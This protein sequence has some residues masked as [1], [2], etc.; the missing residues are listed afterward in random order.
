MTMQTDVQS[1]HLNVSGFAVLGRT[2]LRGIIVVGSATAGTV[3]IWDSV[4]APTAAATGYTRA[5]T[6]I[7]TVTSASHGLQ[8]GGR[9]GL[10]FAVQGS[11]GGTN[12]NY[13]ILTADANTFTVQDINLAAIAS[14]TACS[15]LGAST[16]QTQWMMSFD[17]AAVTSGSQIVPLTLPGEG[18]L[19]EVGI[20]I[21]MSNQTGA[22]IFYG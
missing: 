16:N 9:V 6:G 10:T 4:T 13:T 18:M 7:I 21:Q 8:A 22:T 20:Y 11:A 2:R 1:A 17:T 15:F 19:A 14:S 5:A 3:N 12:G